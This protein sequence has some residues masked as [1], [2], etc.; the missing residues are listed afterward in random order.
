[1]KKYDLLIFF[2]TFVWKSIQVHLEC[3]KAIHNSYVQVTL[4]WTQGFVQLVNILMNRQNIHYFMG[5]Y[6]SE[7]GWQEGVRL[8]SLTK[9]VPLKAEVWMQQK[10]WQVSQVCNIKGE[11]ELNYELLDR[12]ISGPVNKTNHRYRVVL[13]V[14]QVKIIPKY[15][16]LIRHLKKDTEMRLEITSQYVCCFNQNVFK[17]KSTFLACVETIWKLISVWFWW[18]S[19]EKIHLQKWTFSVIFHETIQF[20]F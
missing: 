8:L 12:K 18:N 14:Q 20:F 2:Q 6:S 9:S 7:F 1:M 3:R 4:K 11:I 16:V 19:I 17:M 5:G 15:S 13:S 10:G